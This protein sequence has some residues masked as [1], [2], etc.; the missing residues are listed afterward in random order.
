[1]TEIKVKLDCSESPDSKAWAEN[2][3]KIAREWFPKLAGLMDSG[4][5]QPVKSITLHFKKMDGVAHSRGNTITISGNWIKK[6]PGDWG[7]LIHEMV[8]VI[9]AYRGGVPGWVTEGIADYIRFYIYE[10]TGDKACPVNPDRAKYTDSYRTT[11]AFFHW[12]VQNSGN[13]NF[14]IQL[15]ERC[16]NRQYSDAVFPDLIGKTVDE[17]W[18]EFTAVLRGRKKGR[19]VYFLERQG[20]EEETIILNH[21]LSL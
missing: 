16:R 6:H 2:A 3:A 5:V 8:H 20:G 18:N 4:G 19:D 7:M 17:L 1:V 9:Q 10:K 13:K 21:R 12:I 15:N 14:I 11:A